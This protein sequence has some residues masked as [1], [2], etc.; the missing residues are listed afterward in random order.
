M[1]A[2]VIKA[3]G[4]IENLDIVDLPKPSP[5]A[6]E[7]LL[8]VK[9]VALN[10]LDL[11]VRRGSP[12]LRLTLP[13]IPGSDAAGVIA[14]IG[15]NVVGLQ[16]GQRVV[17]NAG[18]S[19]G[20]CEFCIAGQECLCPEFKIFG[21]HVSGGAAEFVR[22]PA[23]NVLPIPDALSFEQAAAASLVFLTA[24]RALVTRA[25]VRAGDD[26]L[27]LG[28]GAGTSTA[29]IQ[30]A[31]KAGA[32][33]FVTS[34]S[35]EKLQRAKELGADVLV[36]Y[37]ANPEWDRAIFAATNKRGVDVVFESVGAETWLKS[38]RSLRKGGRM[39]V[40]GATT[41]PRPQEEIGYIFWK[42]IEIIGSTMSTQSEFRD[43]MKL[44]FRGELKPVI[45][46]IYPLEQA[47]E[48]HARLEKG[49]QFG[50]IVLTV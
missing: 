29:A 19:C 39:V 9:A 10:Q 40:I 37:K 50:K 5:A 22:I 7:V 43:V 8:N 16:P 31:K 11:F 1:K 12:A 23:R 17:I 34:S 21:E 25:R 38:I 30:I 2:L 15:S 32:R 48:A 42:Q 45:D 41:G 35:D 46:T 36:N 24:W 28:A 6:D 47:R 33:V 18:L 27:I 14:E 44:I 26:V 3:H 4:G 20:H 13:H 49:E